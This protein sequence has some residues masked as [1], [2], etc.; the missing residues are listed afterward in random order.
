MKKNI[1]IN[2]QGM[3][4]HIEEDGYEVL[5]RYLAE[6]KAHFSGYRGHE[7][8]VA[9][10]E[11]RI[12]ELFAARLSGVKQV[13]TLE[14]VEA[15]TAK[16]G[17]VSDFQSADEAEDDE[18]IL[19]EAVASGTAQGTYT[20]SRSSTGGY[21][22]HSGRA[23]TDSGT[24]TAPPLEEPG[25]KRLYR[26]MAHRKIAGVAAGLGQY[27]SVNPLW[28]RLGFLALFIIL[29]IALDNS[30]LD[31]I[32]GNFAGFAFLSYIVLWIVLPK[33]YDATITEAD[34]VFKKLYRDTDNGKVGGVSAG[35]AAYFRVDVVLIRI[36]FIVGLFA[37]GFA[38]PLYII[39]WILLPE[40]KTASDKLRM[41]GD[42]VTLSA[43]DNNIRNNPYAA[44][45]EAGAVNNRPVGTFLENSFDNVRPLINSIGS[46]IRVF[47]GGILAITGFG[48]LLAVTIG[49]GIGL[50]I[51]SASDGLDYGPLQPFLLFNDIS[52]WAVLSFFLATGIPA[53]AL[54]LA[55]IGL[56]LHRSVLSRTAW[57]SLLGLWLLG[58]VGSSVAG[59]RLGREFQR[60]SEVTQTVTLGGLTRP[61]LVLER[62]QLEDDK[63]LDLDI[64][65]IDSAQAPRVERIISAK[66]ATDSLA[67]RTA[68]TSTLHN[69]RVLNDS[70]LSV[71][72]HF[73][74]KPNARFRDQHMQ[75]RLLMPRDRKFRM[76]ETF[77]DWLS[78]DDFMNERP[79]YHPERFVYRMNGNKV[80]C[81][82]CT[83]SDL[84][85]GANSDNEEDEDYEN[86][87]EDSDMNLSFGSV[88]PINTDENSYGSERQRFDETNFDH[89]SVVGGYHVLVRQSSSYSVRAAGDGRALRDIKVERDGRE[90]TISPRNRDLF[91]S[92]RGD[93]DEVLLIIETPE[94]NDLSLVGGTK[95][96]VEGFNTGNLRVQQAGGSQLRF[97]GNLKELKLELAG[98]CQT[99]LQGSADNLEI[100]GTGACEVAG[101][102]FTARRADVDAIGASKVRLH[103][104]DELDANAVG[105]SLIEYS[106]R[107]GSVHREAIGAAAIRA[108]D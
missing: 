95:A 33:R 100:S 55:G 70:T 23:T 32:A 24:S 11:S 54:M 56:L 45:S 41:R 36:L 63:W 107:P 64:V 91:D 48:M 98:G 94:L 15:M 34:A 39:L 106:G 25:T 2:L 13:I 71:D 69:L 4:F 75:L 21:S 43:L 93:E 92:K 61:Q 50:G 16:M 10:I 68:A 14:D 89:V 104:S 101:A 74:Y 47:A 1:S 3:I 22:N 26:D 49:L 72:D 38:L 28:I 66:G 5:G 78:D 52:P 12:A 59:I 37:G 83:E 51:I 18:E 19:A 102:E 96:Q 76:S 73:T 99:A 7:E 58:V 82:N 60:E 6:V 103:V 87:R 86:G 81:L 80:E 30:R 105:A 108:V 46:L 29:P 90:I 9:D 20:G 17:R 31:D 35:L 79:P 44:G 97:R 85:G 88:E 27:F 53:L 42:A 65:G 57:L 67:R 8:I 62:R 84:R 40:A 77:A